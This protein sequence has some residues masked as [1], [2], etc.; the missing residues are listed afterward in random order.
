MLEEF[1]IGGNLTELCLCMLPNVG[2]GYALYYLLN[3]RFKIIQF[4][5]ILTILFNFIQSYPPASQASWEVANLTEIKVCNPRIWWQRLF[6][7]LVWQ[8]MFLLKF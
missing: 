2:F 3:V 8:H 6:N 7:L 1:L 4:Y 5:S